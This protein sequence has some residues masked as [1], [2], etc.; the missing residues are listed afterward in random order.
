MGRL[1]PSW[2]P[3]PQ[4]RPRKG[5]ERPLFA[6]VKAGSW[7]REELRS[8]RPAGKRISNESDVTAC[9][10]S[11]ID[12][13][14]G[15]LLVFAGAIQSA[16]NLEQPIIS[17]LDVLLGSFKPAQRRRWPPAVVPFGSRSQP[18]PNRLLR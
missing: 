4:T 14:E 13:I 11:F 2:L 15:L 9:W 5:R 7:L 1:A 18:A 17:S 6:P 12:T 3:A 16:D 8:C 10:A